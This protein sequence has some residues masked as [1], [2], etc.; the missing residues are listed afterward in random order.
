MHISSKRYIL[1]CYNVSCTINGV[2]K[3]I[4]QHHDV[5]HVANTRSKPPHTCIYMHK[6]SLQST[7][8]MDD[9]GIRDLNICVI[10]IFTGPAERSGEDWSS[11][12]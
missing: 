7:V 12:Q 2:G 3:L 10:Y 4:S 9:T 11:G 1:Q 8:Q 5:V 6:I